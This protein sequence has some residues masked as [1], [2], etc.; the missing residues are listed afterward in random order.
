MSDTPRILLVEGDPFVAVGK[1]RQMRDEWFPGGPPPGGWTVFETP[2]RGSF[3][4]FFNSVQ[5][6]VSCPD[7]D[8][9]HRVVVLRGVLN[10]KAFR[11]CLYTLFDSVAQSNTLVILDDDGVTVGHAADLDKADESDW[12]A[13]RREVSSRGKVLNVGLP[14]S[15]IPEAGRVDYVM[16]CM[17]AVGKPVTYEV[18]KT[19]MS[20]G[21]PERWFLVP[22]MKKIAEA[23]EGEAVTEK[24]VVEAIMPVSR[25]HEWWDLHRAIDGGKREEMTTV[26]ADLVS[27]GH[28]YDRLASICA[29]R[30]RWHLAY[31]SLLSYGAGGQKSLEAFAACPKAEDARKAAESRHDL[32]RALRPVD[33]G[34]DDGPKTRGRAEQLFWRS[35]KE[36][37]AAVANM[38]PRPGSTLLDDALERYL[39]AVDAMF[40]VRVAP[41]EEKATVFQEAVRKMSWR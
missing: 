33:D 21:P 13:L 35:A 4:S 15:M 18:A 36:I 23:C 26:A 39:A 27:A 7:W 6:E 1:L 8:D 20:F 5:A 14:L 37:V 2:R 9:A 30:L 19:I 24:D 11:K 40:D 31:A 38:K 16:R 25:E 12:N 28:P 32:R 10:T 3:D 34:D 41:Q 22:E 29:S 17:Q